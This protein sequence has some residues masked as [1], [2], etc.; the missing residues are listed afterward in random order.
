[1]RWKQRGNKTIP[2][3]KSC[4]T[5]PLARIAINGEAVIMIAIEKA[6]YERL[7]TNISGVS[8]TTSS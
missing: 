7:E 4:K 2:L 5:D 1:L 8:E 6:Y 3:Q